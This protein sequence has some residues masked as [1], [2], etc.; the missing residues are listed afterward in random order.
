MCQKISSS[1][2]SDEEGVDGKNYSNKDGFS[3]DDN[4]FDEDEEEF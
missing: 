4:I 3:E 2:L 1:S